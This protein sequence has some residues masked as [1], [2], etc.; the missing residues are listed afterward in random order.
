M[1]PVNLL[2]QWRTKNTNYFLNNSLHTYCNSTGVVVGGG[3]KK[4]IYLPVYRSNRILFHRNNPSDI[5]F[6]PVTGS[7]KYVYLVLLTTD[8]R[9]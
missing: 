9:W 4:E 8:I 2:W 3:V 5:N 1:M 7:C 6:D